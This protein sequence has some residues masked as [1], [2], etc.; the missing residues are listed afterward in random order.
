MSI[1]ML[2][3]CLFIRNNCSVCP[4]IWLIELDKLDKRLIAK[5]AR[6][7]FLS[8]NMTTLPPTTTDSPDFGFDVFSGVSM[9]NNETFNNSLDLGMFSDVGVRQKLTRRQIYF[10]AVFRSQWSFRRYLRLTM[11]Q[12]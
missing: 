7:A 10:M 5:E 9:N 11:I 12:S 8:S 4:S 1:L 3:T 2:N 6:E